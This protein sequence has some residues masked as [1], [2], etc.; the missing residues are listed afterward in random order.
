M[1][2]RLLEYS[3]TEEFSSALVML[4]GCVIG[5]DGAKYCCAVEGGEVSEDARGSLTSDGEMA[6]SRRRSA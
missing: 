3:D 6:S 4:V 2:P 5:T 1:V